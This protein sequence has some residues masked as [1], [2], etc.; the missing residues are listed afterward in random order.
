M[1]EDK[2]NNTNDIVDSEKEDKDEYEKLS[3]IHI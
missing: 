2:I 3:L 1:S